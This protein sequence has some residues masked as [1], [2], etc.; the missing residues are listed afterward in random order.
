VARDLIKFV[1]TLFRFLVYFYRLK[2]ICHQNTPKLYL[3][4]LLWTYL[5]K[6]CRYNKLFE[7]MSI[8]RFRFTPIQAGNGACNYRTHYHLVLSHET[9]QNQGICYVTISYC[10][11]AK[12]FVACNKFLH[13]KVACD[14]FKVGQACSRDCF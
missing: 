10:Y 5:P 9:Y 8:F 1:S 2:Y 3:L 4:F 12:T 11:V 6:T 13:V 14:T 7:N